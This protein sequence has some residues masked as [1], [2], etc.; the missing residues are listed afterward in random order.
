MAYG[1]LKAVADP[2]QTSRQLHQDLLATSKKSL[3]RDGTI[4][5]EGNPLG[6]TGFSSVGDNFIRGKAGGGGWLS[7]LALNT[8]K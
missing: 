4:Q 2:A 8:C 7:A 1:W 3:R 6:K 5:I